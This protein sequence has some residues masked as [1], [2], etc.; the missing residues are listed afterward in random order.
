MLKCVFK[1]NTLLRYNWQK[2]NCTHFRCPT[3]KQLLSNQFIL[4]RN[5]N[6]GTSLSFFLSS[7]LSVWITHLPVKSILSLSQSGFCSHAS[8]EIAVARLHCQIQGHFPVFFSLESLG[9]LPSLTILS[10]LESVTF[11]GIHKD[12]LCWSLSHHKYGPSSS[13]F[14]SLALKWWQCHG[15][16]LC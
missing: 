7:K 9:L 6:L 16:T 13:S 4:H 1:N 5:S 15:S 3:G 2:I 8:G 12:T 11:L 14:P 10:H